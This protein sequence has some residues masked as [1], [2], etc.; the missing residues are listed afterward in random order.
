MNSIDRV[1]SL[2]L[3]FIFVY[4]EYNNIWI[5]VR[6]DMIEIF[7]GRFRDLCQKKFIPS[8][9]WTRYIGVRQCLHCT[10]GPKQYQAR[11]TECL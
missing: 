11:F 2:V 8:N 3:L 7:F 4:C 1:H 10:K 5:W 9:H 6:H